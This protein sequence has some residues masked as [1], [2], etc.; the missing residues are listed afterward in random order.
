MKFSTKAEYGLRAIV[1]LDKAGKKSVSLAWI[2]DKEKI[3]LSYL[4][5]LFASLKKAGLFNEVKD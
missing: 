3:S 4:E 5:R 2:A 1:H